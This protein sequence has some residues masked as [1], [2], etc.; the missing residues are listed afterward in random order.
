MGLP[1]ALRPIARRTALLAITAL[2]IA[3]PGA[4]TAAPPERVDYFVDESKLPF[5]ALE[6]T[7]ST[8]LW[9]VHGDAGYRIEV[10]ADWNGELVLYA[11]G[12][13]GD[14]A[15]LTVSNPE[16]R[17]YFVSQGYAWAASSYSANGYA[18]KE[19]VKDTHA[20]T[21][22]FNG[23]V[24]KPDRV[25]IHGPSMGGHI[26]AVAIE[27]HRSTYDG[28]LPYCGVLGDVEL[29]D[30]FLDYNVVAQE[31]AGID[32][33]FPP[34]PATYPG[35]V[36]NEIE[37]ELGSPF[38]GNPP[39]FGQNA[40]LSEAGRDLRDVVEQ[41]TGGT[42]AGFDG[43]FDFWN[44]FGFGDAPDIPFLFGLYGDGTVNGRTNGNVTT[45]VETV[46]QLDGDPA[47]TDEERSLND[48]VLRVE[49]D[50][51]ARQPGGL[52]DIPKIDG[53]PT[54]PVL[55]LHTTGD[56]FV[57]FSM[58]QIYLERAQEEGAD[59]NVVVR[60]V[61][62]IRHCGFTGAELVEGFSD[63]VD[64]VEDGTRPS[65]D[66]ILDPAAV[67]DPDFGCAFSRGGHL[68]FAPACPTG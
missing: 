64:W 8:R 21:K 6:G 22:R 16:L 38:A 13:R 24:G 31:L 50:P 19:G 57:P 1:T 48:A 33:I 62:D 52:A 29:F 15:E 37:P 32:G 39:V 59:D 30:S 23:L 46:Y 9:G 65:G 67:A 35:I 47:L 63:L 20:L 43:A 3:P 51:S 42:R 56:L 49:A 28:A 10:P 2:L 45:N 41:R 18:V 61:R 66:D 34:D 55:S 26:T 12:F 68:F 25:Y 58:E 11:H 4:A 54:I 40:V 14:G 36:T 27:H 7:D 60:A 53:D 5:E 17:A 44:S